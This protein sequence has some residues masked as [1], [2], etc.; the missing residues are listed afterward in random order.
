MFTRVVFVVLCILS[1]AVLANGPLHYTPWSTPVSLGTNVNTDQAEFFS[2]ISKDGLSLYFTGKAG[3]FQG[4]C[5][6]SYGGWDLFV[7]RRD[8][9]DATWGVPEN[10]G[11]TINTTADEVGP[12]LSPD[13]HR[14][15]FASNRAGGFG[16]NDLYV[17]R[18]H[19]KRDDFGWQPADNLGPG[20]NSGS[21]DASPAI[22]EDDAT[23]EITLYFDS[24]RPEGPGPYTEDSVHN[25]NDIWV[26]VLQPDE[27]FGPATQI[28]ELNTTAAERRPAIRRD[29]LEMILTSNRPGCLGA[30]DLWMTTRP[31]TADPWSTLVN[32]GSEI[33]GPH[34]GGT[35]SL[36]Q[37]AGAAF[38]FDGMSLY[39]QASKHALPGFGNYDL[40]VTTRSKERG[41]DDR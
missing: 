22:F 36:A 25:G 27:T 11:P 32:L 29:G 28:L 17:A 35:A 18:R 10:L 4:V 1:T 26:S 31:T 21:N 20:V 9:L 8:S 19:N 16:G 40:F 41:H 6:S 37:A 30:L 13:G 14:L 24:N 3:C 23:G 34:A 33:N 2:T 7:T 12:A 38:S 15:Y 5:R 39:F